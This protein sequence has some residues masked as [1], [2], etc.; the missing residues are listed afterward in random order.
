MSLLC[1]VLECLAKL[2]LGHIHIGGG[3]AHRMLPQRSKLAKL[4]LAKVFH[5]SVMLYLKSAWRDP[6]QCDTPTS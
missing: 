2:D 5:E 1:H 4:Y 3:P 6:R